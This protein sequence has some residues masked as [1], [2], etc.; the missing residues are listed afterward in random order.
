METKNVAIAT[1]SHYINNAAMAISGRGQ[2]L[3]MLVDRG[4]IVDPDKKLIPVADVIEKSVRKIMAVLQELRELTNLE[5][6][7]KYSDSKAINIDDRVKERLKK[8]DE[9]GIDEVTAPTGRN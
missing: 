2:L 5:D 6:M 7:E 1:L 3:K 8:M 4:T 9:Y